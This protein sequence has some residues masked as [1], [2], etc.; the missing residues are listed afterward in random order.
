MAQIVIQDF[1]LER[2]P[3]AAPRATEDAVYELPPQLTKGG[4]YSLAYLAEDKAVSWGLVPSNQP[5]VGLFCQLRG[6]LGAP[7]PPISQ[8]DA[9]GD[10]LHQGQ[11]RCPIIA[12]AGCQNHIEH[13]T[14]NMA[15]Q[16]E[17][18]AKESPFTAFSKVRSLVPL[19]RVRR[20][21]LP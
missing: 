8:G 12:V 3:Q 19:V 1:E 20:R 15:S 18:E 4:F 21:G 16:M 10:S 6:T 9:P 2:I 7:I 14:S 5:H 13:A 17:F 11:G